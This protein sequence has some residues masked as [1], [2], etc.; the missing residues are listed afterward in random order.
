[1]K[2]VNDLLYIKGKVAIV[3]G[4][5]SGIGQAIAVG[6]AEAGV[7]IA[8]T[9]FNTPYE[10]TKAL[11]EATGQKFFP[12]HVDVSKAEEVG[13]IIPAVIKQYGNFNILINA[14][15]VESHNPIG[16]NYSEEEYQRCLQ[17]NLNQVVALNAEAGKHFIKEGNGGRILNVSSIAGYLGMRSGMSPYVITKHAIRGVTRSFGLELA[18]YGITV[19]A[20]APGPIFSKMTTNPPMKKLMMDRVVATKCPVGRWGFPE[21]FKGIANMLC[22][23]AGGFITGQTIL[24]DGGYTLT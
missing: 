10:E 24:V 22:S 9:Y 23:E 14:A 12:I 18:P 4:S 5:A 20:I 21:D 16:D 15:G 17:I 11:V 1:M 6:L 7:D 3:T 13:N 19:N 2:N 8:G